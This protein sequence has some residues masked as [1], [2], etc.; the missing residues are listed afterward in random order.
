M[1][2]DGRNIIQNQFLIAHLGSY[3]VLNKRKMQKLLKQQESLCLKDKAKRN[4]ASSFSRRKAE[5]LKLSPKPQK[6][7]RK[8]LLLH[9]LQLPV[10]SPLGT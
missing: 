2:F 6:T 1:Y 7:S 5:P 9:H 8:N 3:S 4:Y 10:A